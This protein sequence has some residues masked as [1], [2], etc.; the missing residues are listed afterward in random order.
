MKKKSISLNETGLFS[1]LICDFINSD[2]KIKPF[3]NSFFSLNTIQSNLSIEHDNRDILSSVIKE[4]YNQTVFLNSEMSFVNANI[5]KLS[6]KNTYTITTGH[7]LNVFLNPLFLIYKI[8]SIIA[9]ANYLNNQIKTHHFV[10]CFWMATDDH[11]FD[12]IK[13]LQLY[14]Q[15]YDWDVKGKNAVGNLSSDSIVT[16]LRQIQ[17]LLC[18]THHGQEL[19][20]IYKYA[21]TKNHNYA[22]ATRSLLIALFGDYGLVVVDG[23]HPQLK[24]IFTPHF[25]AEVT[26]SFV[27]SAIA[28][29]NQS[30]KKIYKPQINALKENIFYLH[31]EIRSKIHC[32]QNTYYTHDHP[33]NWSLS[34]LLDEIAE[35]PERFSPNVFLRTLYQECIMPNIL[36]VGGPSET[37]YWLQ[38]KNMFDVRKIHYPLLALRSHFLIVPKKISDLQ[39]RLNLTEL[40]LFKDYHDQLKNII[41]NQ[42]SL[43]LDSESEIFNNQFIEMEKYLNSVKGFP[44]QSLYVFQKRFQTEL[45]RFK[46]KILKFEKTQN[47]DLENKIKLINDALFPNNLIQERTCS[48]IPYYIKYGKDFFNFLI[49]ES[50]IFDNKYTIL[51][52]EE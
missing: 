26:D 7:Q 27:Y 21:Y 33:I 20:D 44:I 32:N 51:T 38:L 41:I 17:P 37:S 25:Q 42:S 47:K 46:S 52:E 50:S 16:L 6:N 11:D 5:S 1:K 18:T 48:F 2:S 39:N 3:I 49:K 29:T 15:N 43:N 14:G 31:N 4:Q 13:T 36:Y 10:P 12:E 28:Q 34:E 45:D 19:F 40:D 9:Y 30:I 22:D 24:K 8:T 23:H 35:F